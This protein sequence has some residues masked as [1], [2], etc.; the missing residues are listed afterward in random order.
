M[1]LEPK[2]RRRSSDRKRVLH[3]KKAATSGGLTAEHLTKNKKGRIV[4]VKLSEKARKSKHLSAWT[5]AVA[6][7]K[8]KLRDRGDDVPN[9]AIPKKGTELY[10]YARKIYDKTLGKSSSKR[11]SFKRNSKRKSRSSL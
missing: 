4:S 11:S 9:F 6:E 8:E 2:K 5:K 10:D 3:G 7:A 1:A